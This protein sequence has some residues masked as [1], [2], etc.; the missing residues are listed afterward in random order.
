M[1]VALALTAGVSADECEAFTLV[2]DQ[3]PDAVVIRVGAALGHV[4]GPGGGQ[5]VEALFDDVASPDVVIVPGGLGCASTAADEALLGWLRS[6]APRCRWMAASS[7]GTV[8]VAAA[9]LLDGQPAAT[10]WLATELLSSYGSQSAPAGIVEIGNVITCEGRITALHVAL[11][12]T[13]RL[14]GPDAVQR[15][16]DGLV[17]GKQAP[18]AP[19]DWRR[20]LP[21]RSPRRPP[22]PARPRNPE[23]IAPDVIEFEPVVV[24]PDRSERK[25]R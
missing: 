19:S 6:V 24:H 20:L 7:T 11:L 5:D 13:L 9:G 10:H 14:G 15:V 8:A 4:D 2:F 16:R 17:A 1:E 22:G 25:S 12:V 21:T 23:L 3:V 18:P